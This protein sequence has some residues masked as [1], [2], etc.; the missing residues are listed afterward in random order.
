[1][2]S[3]MKLFFPFTQS[4]PSSPSNTPSISDPRLLLTLLNLPHPKSSNF[5]FI[6]SLTSNPPTVDNTCSLFMDTN[7]TRQSLHVSSIVGT[8]NE[9]DV[10][11][12][13]AP[14]VPTPRN[15]HAIQ[16]KKKKIKPKAFHITTAL[17]TLIFYTEAS[18]YPEYCWLYMGFSYKI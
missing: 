12:T 4:S 3:F 17:P 2:L 14:S 1:M 8:E 13:N 11:T 7:A 15:T 9:I 10:S 16:N 18:K 6:Q 5:V